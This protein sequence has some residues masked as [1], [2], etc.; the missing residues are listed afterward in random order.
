M[1]KWTQALAVALLAGASLAVTPAA[2]QDQGMDA[3]SGG[4]TA[5]GVVF[6]DAN[7]NGRRDSSETGIEGVAVSN[8][9][10]V[11]AT[12]AEGRY[13]LPVD[14]R[15]ILFVTKPAGHAVPVN[16]TM[17]P[18]FFYVHY[19]NGTPEGLDLRFPGV[20]PTGSLPASVD[21]PLQEVEE[22]TRFSAVLFAD[23]QPQTDAEVSYIRD[24][25]VA[26]LIGTDAAFGITV[27]DVMFDDL[28]LA[29][30]FNAVIGQ[31]GVP[32]YNVPGNH[33][34]NFLS[35][36]DDHSLETYK[37]IYGPPYYSFDYG[38]VHFVVLDNVDYLGRDAGRDE[39]T[40][41]GN[42]MYEGRISERQLDWLRNDLARVPEDKLV[43][44]AHHIPS[45]WPLDEERASV[46][47]LNREQM[48]E[49][50]ANRKVHLVA[51]HTHTTHHV[52]FD[53][54]DGFTG[55][56][57][58]H[59]QILTTVSGSWWSGPFDERGVAV[60]VQRDGVPN[61]YHMARFDG[62]DVVVDY[63]PADH[64][65]DHQMR[66]MF[67]KTFHGY[68]KEGMRDYRMGEIL[69]GRMMI[70]EVPATRLMV[71][72]YDGGPNSTV[73]FQ[74]NDGDATPMERTTDVDPFARELFT[75]N[76]D[77]KKSWVFENG[78]AGDGDR[79]DHMYVADLPDDLPA[80]V[81]NVTVRA[82]DEFGRTHTGRAVL[83]II[84]YGKPSMARNDGVAG[85]DRPNF[86]N[87]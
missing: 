6:N 26:G 13:E 66:I 16:E 18:Q 29:P 46:N 22:P 20:P 59:H 68:S 4:E 39:P 1:T 79:T 63:V 58:L 87:R 52:Y 32:W 73:A 47:T 40:Y 78:E 10:E 19:P 2:G 61:G 62:A 34:L 5:G 43:F 57:P 37:R 45:R 82:T 55:P 64:P 65:A 76:P 54:E 75:R 77:T 35:P 31:I 53:E 12:D 15:T 71:N 17:L 14:D 80:G 72:F 48:F 81:H 38:D 33:E 51:G 36:D 44:V 11:V 60:A 67:D 42:G 41:R 30:R 74:V 83:E 56:E 86:A 84:G 8:G 21:F 24:D 50:L 3:T 27:G 49:V 85:N 28:S 70:D 7:A 9:R 25:L 23:T 69:D